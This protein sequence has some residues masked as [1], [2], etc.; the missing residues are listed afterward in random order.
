[1]RT[2][3]MLLSSA[4]ITASVITACGGADGS[5]EDLQEV[6][7]TCPDTPDGNQARTACQTAVD[8]GDELACE[9]RLDREVFVE[10]GC[11]Q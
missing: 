6:C 11:V 8:S 7:G 5:C 3:A 1:M 2:A 9:D 10:F 4:L